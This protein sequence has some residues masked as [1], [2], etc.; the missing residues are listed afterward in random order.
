M[1]SLVVQYPCIS[2]PQGDREQICRVEARGFPGV[3]G[4][5]SR[6]ETGPTKGVK[7]I[8]KKIVCGSE[9][10]GLVLHPL[11]GKDRQAGSA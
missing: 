11:E 1:A 10:K 2:V 9:K 6:R 8:N 4:S 7:E 5:G 3:N